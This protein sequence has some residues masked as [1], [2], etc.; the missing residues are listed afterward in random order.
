MANTLKVLGW[1]SCDFVIETLFRFVGNTLHRT[2][3]P[4]LKVVNFRRATISLN[5][6]TTS[7]CVKTQIT[8]SFLF[9]LFR[10]ISWIACYA[11]RKRVHE[12]TRNHTN[13]VSSQ[14]RVFDTV[15]AVGG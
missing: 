15:S 6:T 10:V 9:V 2:D 7:D 4:S 3:S 8:V 11:P 13:E 5:P 14:I 12:I 1:V